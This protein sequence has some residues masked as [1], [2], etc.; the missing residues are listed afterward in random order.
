MAP[1]HHVRHRV[2]PIGR[3]ASIRWAMA[4][5]RRDRYWDGP[6]TCYNAVTFIPAAGAS[7]NLFAEIG[8]HLSGIERLRAMMEGGHLTGMEQ[9]LGFRLV[10][11]EE[12]R[13]VIEGTPGLHVYNPFGVV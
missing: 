5:L 13:V 1:R 10:E 8:L 11:A 2:R 6:H 7:M 3:G 4:T 12:G 9:T